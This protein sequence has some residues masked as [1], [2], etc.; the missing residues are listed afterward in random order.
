MQRNTPSAPSVRLGGFRRLFVPLALVCIMTSA[1]STTP[2]TA[3]PTGDAVRYIVTAEDT[4]FYKFGPAQAGGPDMHL[5]KGQALTLMLK[6]YGFSRVQTG[7]GQ[8]GF[9]ATEDI[10]PSPYEP[11]PAAQPQHPISIRT[12]AGHGG[13]SPILSQPNDIPLPTGQPG[14]DTPAPSFRY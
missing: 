8:L 4:P 9:V 3:A 5:K 10:G 1:C 14:S 11:E 7:D 12:G 2:Q 13:G 6:K